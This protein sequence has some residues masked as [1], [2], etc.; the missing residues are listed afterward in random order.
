MQEIP[1]NNADPLAD[2]IPKD[3]FKKK[4]A[5]K[6]KPGAIDWLVRL[7]HENGLAEAIVIVSRKTFINEIK[8]A[9]WFAAQKD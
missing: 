6:L 9:E 7:R 8:F 2:F 4:H 3:K 5:D 1:S